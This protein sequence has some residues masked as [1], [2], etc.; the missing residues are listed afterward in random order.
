MVIASKLALFLFKKWKCIF[1]KVIDFFFSRMEHCMTLKMRLIERQLISGF[2]FILLITFLVS[3][4][5]NLGFKLY[6]IQ[7]TN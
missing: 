1:H 3:R 2:W 6:L 4:K 5:I 7:K